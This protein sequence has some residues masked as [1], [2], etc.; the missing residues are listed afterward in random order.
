M[1]MPVAQPSSFIKKPHTLKRPSLSISV[2]LKDFLHVHVTFFS[3]LKFSRVIL[4]AAR[5]LEETCYCV[6]FLVFTL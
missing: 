1:A 4:V 3:S 6:C 5:I 2:R